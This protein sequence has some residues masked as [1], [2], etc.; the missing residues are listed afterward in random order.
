M[1]LSRSI[2][3][4]FALAALLSSCSGGK[5]EAEL[6]EELQSD[7]RSASQVSFSADI[8]A[9]YGDR[10]YTYGVD[11]SGALSAG[12]LTVTAPDTVAGVTV[13]I[14]DGCASLSYGG[15]EIYTGEIL[16]GGLSPVDAVPVLL[17]AFSNG[18]VTET[19]MEKLGDT[20]CLA[21]LFSVD[22]RV[23]ARAWF[24]TDSSLPLK[25]EISLD[26]ARVVSCDFYDMK[27]E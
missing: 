14:A 13:R 10:V 26:G 22:E 16:P 3:T 27:V 24:D 18:L 17:G 5:D 6:M 1:R 8:E 2:C 20:D 12:T 25:A 19:V 7:F 11:Y 15:T 9:D 21:A 4:F 23:E